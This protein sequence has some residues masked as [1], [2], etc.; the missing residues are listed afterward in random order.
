MYIAG[1]GAS[2]NHAHLAVCPVG[3]VHIRH[4]SNVH[5]TPTHGNTN[6][7]KRRCSNK[8]PDSSSSHSY[9][10]DDT[11]S[12]KVRNVSSGYRMITH[13]SPSLSMTGWDTTLVK[14]PEDFS[15]ELEHRNSKHG[16]SKLHSV[17]HHS[18]QSGWATTPSVIGTQCF[19]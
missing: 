2:S 6:H 5:S 3:T 10:V 13:P 11:M 1:I 19:E 18:R 12:D 4:V 8:T 16:G 14:D 17:E 9:E 15:E 7:D